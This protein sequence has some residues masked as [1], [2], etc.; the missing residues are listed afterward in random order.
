M[1]LGSGTAY[2]QGGSRPP[3]RNILRKDERQRQQDKY[4]VVVLE[5]HRIGNILAGR[6]EFVCAMHLAT[7]RIGNTRWTRPDIVLSIASTHI[8][9]KKR[10]VHPLHGRPHLDAEEHK[11]GQAENGRDAPFNQEDAVSAKPLN[12]IGEDH[13]LGP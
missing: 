3:V 13:H 5:L 10:R 8:P 12:K 7:Q 2:R 4:Q 11:G 1:A 6:F 9:H